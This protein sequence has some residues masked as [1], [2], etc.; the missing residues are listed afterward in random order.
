MLLLVHRLRRRRRRDER[1]FVSNKLAFE[2]IIQ[3]ERG[4]VN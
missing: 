1:N 4:V 3:M 2:I